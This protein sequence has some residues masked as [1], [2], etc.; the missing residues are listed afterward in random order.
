MERNHLRGVIGAAISVAVHGEE[1]AAYTYAP[2]DANGTRCQSGVAIAR[3]TPIFRLDGSNALNIFNRSLALGA[4][5]S[6]KVRRFSADGI[7][8][9]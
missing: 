7:R 3:H 9:C 4:C 5:Q 6:C 2:D 1:R 8:E